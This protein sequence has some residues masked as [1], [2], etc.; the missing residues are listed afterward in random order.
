MA[1]FRTDSLL[2][3]RWLLLTSSAVIGILGMASVF[4]ALMTAG[5]VRVSLG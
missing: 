5:I 4:Q 3:T 2:I 1:R